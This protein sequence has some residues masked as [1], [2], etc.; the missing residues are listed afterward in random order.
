MNQLS[1]Q[2]DD[3]QLNKILMQQKIKIKT[4]NRRLVYKLKQK[5]RI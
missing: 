5:V 3:M 2:I 1:Y 4:T